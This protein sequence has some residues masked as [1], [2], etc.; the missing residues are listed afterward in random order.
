[1]SELKPSLT[2][3]LPFSCGRVFNRITHNAVKTDLVLCS[4]ARWKTKT[5]RPYLR[6]RSRVSVSLA[7]SVVGSSLVKRSDPPHKQTITWDT[8]GTFIV[9]SPAISPL[10]PR[11]CFGS[12]LRQAPEKPGPTR[13]PPKHI[14]TASLEQPPTYRRGFQLW[15]HFFG[16]EWDS[17]LNL[18]IPVT[19]FCYSQRIK[20]H[21]ANLLFFLSEICH[22]QTDIQMQTSR[23]ILH[24]HPK[25]SQICSASVC[26]A[27]RRDTLSTAGPLNPSARAA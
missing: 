22:T 6:S 27:F 1:M 25:H 14:Q 26:E 24:S 17:W 13:L 5:N 3:A 8:T 18:L 10:L 11:L 12:S 9:F 23:T 19:A 20:C 2:V 4:A 7:R 15:M 16:S 21:I